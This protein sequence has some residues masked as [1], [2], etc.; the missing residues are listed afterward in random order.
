MDTT[1]YSIFKY[2]PGNRKNINQT[3]I[4]KLK[5]KILKHG[6]LQSMPVIVNENYEIIDGQHR[7][8]ACKQLGIPVP[9]VIE[10]DIQEDLLIDLNVSQ[11]KWTTTDFVAYY[12]KER[13]NKNYERLEELMDI[14]KL[15]V[16]TALE[17]AFDK[18]LGGA[19]LQHI[20]E[21]N[22]TLEATHI[23][24]ARV[25]FDAIRTI[26]DL[27]HFR[28][29]G[30]LCRALNTMQRHPSFSWTKLLEKARNYRAKTY[31][32]STKQEWLEMFVTLY[33]HNSKGTGSKINMRDL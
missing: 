17:L 20:K 25:V 14:T 6:Y 21:G 31:P 8:E 27:L 11:K 22:L 23:Q 24:H 3:H 7:V 5:E 15:D 33:N 16:T 12:A 26:A 9:Y 29:T 28:I 30:R 1:E 4:E 19:G 13:H 10:K 32:C 18:E 2:K